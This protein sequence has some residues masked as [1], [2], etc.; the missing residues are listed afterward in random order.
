MNILGISCFYHDSAACLMKDGKIVAAAQEERFNRR[1]N[2]E[3]FPIEAINFCI[4]A[5]DITFDAID[6]V[7]FYEKPYLKFSRVLVQHLRS[8]P[9]SFKNFLDTIPSWLC[10]RLILPSVLEKKLGYKGNV[11]FIKHHLSHAASAF[12]VSP[13]DRAAIMTADA[14][15]EWASMTWGVGNGNDIKIHKEMRYPDSLGL[16]YTAVTTYLGFKAHSGEGKVM[17]LAG[18]GKPAYIDELKKIV[19]LRP[20]GSI[21][22]DTSYFNFNRGARMYTNRFVRKFGPPRMPETEPEQKYCDMAASLQKLTEDA[23]IAAA[24]N[25]YNETKI[26]KLCLAGG[27]FLNCIAN[28]KIR[29]ETPF[30]EIFIQPAAG[31]SGGAIGAA[32]YIEHV[33]LRRP[34]TYVMT[35]ASLGP[36]FFERHIKRALANHNLPFRELND[37]D[38]TKYIAEKLAQGKIIG[39]FHGRMELGP[40]AL[41]NRSILANPSIPGIKDTVNARV[42]KR[43]AFRPFAPAV[44]VEKSAEYFDMDCPSPFMLLAPL[45]RQ[46]KKNVIPG[47]THVDDTARVQTVDRENFPLFWQLIKEFENIT[48]VPVLLNTSLNLRGEPIVCTPEDAIEV[49]KKSEIDYLVLENCVVEKSNTK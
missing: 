44:L 32:A 15:G 33:L 21:K 14:V 42:K 36:A 20:D 47:I 40:R 39:W 31:D 1:K 9:F 29:Q 11:V 8:Y 26:D 10:D 28:W 30:K 38:L 43:E 46:E 27:I 22:V 17:G 35:T 12:L 49:F 45:V 48:G 19:S 37:N 2:S 6:Y 4:Q 16:I 18:Y 7:G 34:R 24:R 3:E 23:L 41:G 13:F 5:G 25:L